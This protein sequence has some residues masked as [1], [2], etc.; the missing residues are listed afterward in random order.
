MENESGSA[1]FMK[2]V[3]AYFPKIPVGLIKSKR[4]KMK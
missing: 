2:W 3:M 1:T 4:R